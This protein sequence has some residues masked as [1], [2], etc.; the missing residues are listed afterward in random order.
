VAT[1]TP[2]QIPLDASVLQQSLIELLIQKGVIS[3]DE[4]NAR[5]R[6]VSSRKPTSN[7]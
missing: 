3:A 5:V 2:A 4:W 6:L 1:S 7:R